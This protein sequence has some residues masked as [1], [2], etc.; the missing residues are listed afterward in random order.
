MSNQKKCHH[1]YPYEDE[2][3]KYYECLGSDSF[4]G[5]CNYKC[6]HCGKIYVAD[7]FT[8]EG[9]LFESKW[10]ELNGSDGSDEGFEMDD[11]I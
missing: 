10:Y 11:D 7:M 8:E 5:C 2:N 4:D 3:P 9:R 1:N 6:K